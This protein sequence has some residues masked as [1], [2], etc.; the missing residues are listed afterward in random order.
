MPWNKDG[1]RKTM[2][3]KKPSTFK[4]RS[5]NTPLFKQ[6]GSSPMKDNGWGKVKKFVKKGYEGI[7][8][9]SKDISSEVSELAEPVTSKIKEF[10]E[11]YPTIS[12][13]IKT[14]TNPKTAIVTGIVEK[15]KEI[16]KPGLSKEEYL[17]RRG[18]RRKVQGGKKR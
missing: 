5:G 18:K 2:A 4:M 8:K 11:D 15:I 1:S 12:K 13:T 14:V 16:N 17:K 6:M 9:Y 3:Y 7:K 10:K